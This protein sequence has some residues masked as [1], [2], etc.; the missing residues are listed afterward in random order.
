VFSIRRLDYGASPYGKLAAYK[1]RERWIP[2]PLPPPVGPRRT[3][4]EG[5]GRT[6]L[7][8][9]TALAKKGGHPFDLERL[10]PKAMLDATIA[11]FGGGEKPLEVLIG[12]LIV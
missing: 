2:V 12:K 8:F 3:S 10:D 4:R 5:N 11:S 7:S 9:M 6:Q 1:F